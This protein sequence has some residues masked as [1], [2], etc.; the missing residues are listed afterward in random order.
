M[1][2]FAIRLTAT[3]TVYYIYIHDCN[4][5]MFVFFSDRLICL[6]TVLVQIKR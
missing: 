5:F 2:L 6:D 1:K 4:E 3:Y